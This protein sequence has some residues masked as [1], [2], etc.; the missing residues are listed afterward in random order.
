MHTHTQSQYFNSISK[1]FSNRSNKIHYSFRVMNSTSCHIIPLLMNCVIS[2]KLVAFFS[3][4]K[5]I[6]SCHHDFLQL[7]QIAAVGDP[8]RK[9][10]I[11][12]F[13]ILYLG[14]E[15]FSVS[16]LMC[17]TGE[18]KVGVHQT[19]PVLCIPT[20][21]LKKTHPFLALTTA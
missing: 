21:L 7:S 2:V 11:Y 13:L 4:F 20:F 10:K 16:Q 17:C 19:L 14:Q 15:T 9:I 5:W 18:I 3:F 12:S 1:H 8:R 6:F